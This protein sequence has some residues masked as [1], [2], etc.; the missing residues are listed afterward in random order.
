MATDQPNPYERW[1]V[2]ADSEKIPTSPPPQ[3]LPGELSVD[4]DAFD[5]F[6]QL[7]DVAFWE[8]DFTKDSMDRTRNHDALYG[9]EWQQ[10]WTA[11]S[12]LDATHPD[13]R[14]MA[15]AVFDRVLS[16]GGANSYAFDFRVI[17]P[18]ASTHWLSVRGQVIARDSEG[19][20]A[21]IRGVIN[22]VTPRK[23]AEQREHRLAVLYHTLS[24][25]NQA[26][27]R[28][29]DPA[30]LFARVC[31][32]TVE[33]GGADIAWI[34]MVDD[35][36]GLIHP[37]SWA[38]ADAR[39]LLSERA[40]VLA[41]GTSERVAQP[42][43]DAH[44]TL[45]MANV[46]D[47]DQGDPLRAFH[48][49]WSV[50]DVAEVPI[51]RDGSVIGTLNLYAKR[52]G[53]FDGHARSLFVEMAG[54]IAFALGHLDQQQA[55]LRQVEQTEKSLSGTVEVASS[56][57]EMRDPYTAGHQRN[58]GDLAAAI[59]EVLGLDA[60]RIVGLRV[61]GRLHDIG[62]IVIPAE[63][64]T[65]P[66][67]LTGPE[68]EIVKAHAQLGHD[69]LSAAPF[70]W[71]VAQIALQHHERLDGSGYPRGLAGDEILLEARITSVADVFEAMSAHRPY[72][73]ALGVDRA[74][75][76]L[77]DGAGTRYDADA[78]AACVLLL[79]ERG[80]HF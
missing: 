65:R 22:D 13:D 28:S 16:A 62:K 48:E 35:E 39:N 52:S 72:R 2:P 42:R 11:A 44:G 27:V 40:S 33:A 12:F 79:R 47:L 54:D 21:M 50:Q 20:G 7:G 76:E 45:S 3:L 80:F 36:T 69:V 34:G 23:E 1:V 51:L 10:L 18:D 30:E 6:S 53:S 15:E 24:E 58:V 70:P 37:M 74:L 4:A 41:A 25:C 77:Q 64:L 5:R 71:P 31:R 43:T 75:A 32:T 38:G 61:A 57:S 14:P 46:Q 17:W 19:R 73:P 8:Y 68:W 55:L 67:R 29:A 66:S 56:L 9:M 60:D 49:R 63:I 78:V 59:G 26:I